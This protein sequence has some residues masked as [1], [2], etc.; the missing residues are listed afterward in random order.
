MK[1]FGKSFLGAAAG[2]VF[3]FLIVLFFTNKSSEKNH[4]DT[5]QYSEYQA[6]KPAYQDIPVHQSNY[7]VPQNVD[8]TSAA[9]KTVNAVVH[10]KTEMQVKTTSYD[11][12]FG[13]FRHYFGNP[14]HNNTYV[15]FGSGVIISPDGYI[16]TNNHVV[17]GADKVTVTFN[18]KEEKEATII[19]TDPTTDLALIKVDGSSLVYLNY[20]NS[21]NLK[22]GEWVLAVGNPFNLTS[23]VTAGIVSAKARN[24]HILG[25]A[26]AIESF[27]QTDA[28]VNRGNSGGALVNTHGELVGINAAIASHT[29]VYEGYSFAIPVNIVQKV[30]GDLMNYGEIQRAYIGVQ[31][32]D[33]DAHFA[34]ELG[35][36]QVRGVYIASIVESGGADE[37]GMQEGDV[38]LSINGYETN[39][40]STLMGTIAQHSPGEIVNIEVIRNNKL[41]NYDVILKNQNNTTALVKAED[42]FF[43]E[44]LGASLQ[45]VKDQ[46]LDAMGITSGLKIINIDDGILRR[47]GISEGFII[48]DIN[49][50]QVNSAITLKRAIQSGK[51]NYVRLRGVYPNGTKVSYEFML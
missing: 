27:I 40:L 19:G 47:G 41:L 3:V 37:A 29:G 28:V 2:T 10:I 36:E 23:T 6:Q 42:S 11:D 9:E 43:N 46:E 25:A 4:S 38:I 20:G 12:F 32:R 45:K 5:L 31:I 16:V 21:D 17:E 24:I 34:D 48:T 35:L 51:G 30:V 22:I 15:A 7:P 50:V 13:T 18:N 33:I 1:I 26:S 39:S 14:Y 49:G 8:L 44:M